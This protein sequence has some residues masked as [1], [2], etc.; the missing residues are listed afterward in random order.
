MNAGPIKPEQGPTPHLKRAA[1]SMVSLVNDAPTGKKARFEEMAAKKAEMRRQLEEKRKH[2][3]AA[4]QAFE[5]QRRAR[6]QAEKLRLE[7]EEKEMAMLEQQMAEE[8]STV[9]PLSLPCCK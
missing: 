4:R 2:K 1:S 9:F 8:V 6:E 7:A 5:D 3:N